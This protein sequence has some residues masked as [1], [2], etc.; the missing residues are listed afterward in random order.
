MGNHWAIL[1]CAVALCGCPTVDLGDTPPDIGQCNPTKG[2]AYFVS[3]I[4]PQFLKI[5]DTANGCARSTSC[6]LNAHGL[7]LKT[8]PVDD[9]ANYRI[10][11][12]YLNCGQPQASELL[13]KPLKG[14]DAHGGGDLFADMSDPAVQ[15]FL[16]WFQ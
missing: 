2:Q 1:A 5:T 7:T 16:A 8:N 10:T 13:T 9:A 4:E 6:H 11:Q 12:Q 15:A 14:I 3:T